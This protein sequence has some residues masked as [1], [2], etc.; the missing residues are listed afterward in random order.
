MLRK[1]GG[2][3]LRARKLG[4]RLPYPCL[5]PDAPSLVVAVNSPLEQSPAGPCNMSFRKLYSQEP[6]CSV[7]QQTTVA[8]CSSEAT[9][10]DIL[11]AGGASLLGLCL[12]KLVGE[13]DPTNILLFSC[14]P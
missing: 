11:T 5:P 7:R 14:L 9:G 12:L 3:M 10:P 13:L 1:W 6:S 4:C 8:L 2:L